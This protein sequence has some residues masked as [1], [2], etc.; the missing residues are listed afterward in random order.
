MTRRA[1][2]FYGNY[3]AGYLRGLTILRGRFPQFLADLCV[4]G[5]IYVVDMNVGCDCVQ[6][7]VVNL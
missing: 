7:F 2:Y 4:A 6:R 3:P 1:A 5:E